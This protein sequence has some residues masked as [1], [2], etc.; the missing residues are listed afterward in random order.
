MHKQGMTFPAIANKVSTPEK[1]IKWRGVLKNFTYIG[2]DLVEGD[3][4]DLV[5]DDP[6]S[7]DPAEKELDI[8]IIEKNTEINIVLVIIKIFP[9]H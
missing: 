8:N 5:L 6:L 9:F 1:K 4:V 7:L 2:V 3:N